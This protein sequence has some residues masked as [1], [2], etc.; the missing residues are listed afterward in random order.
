MKI[1]DVCGFYSDRGGGV[2]TYVRQK[3]LRAAAAGHEAAVI[4]PGE[5]DWVEQVEGGVVHWVTSPRMPFDANYRLLIS[6]EPVWSI[7]DREKPDI[8]E[9]SS[10]WRG[11]W[12]AGTWPGDAVKSLVFHQD[13][14]AG[15][16]Y[17]LLGGVMDRET[18]DSLFT[19]YW[20]WLRRLSS[21]F[22]VTLTGADW[23]ADRVRSFGLNNPISIP[24]GVDAGRF[25]AHLRDEGLRA[26]LLAECGLPPEAKLLLTVGRLHPEKRH[27]TMLSGFAMARSQ[28]QDLGL[29]I[30]GEGMLRESVARRA[31]MIGGVRLL[32]AVQD[33]DHLARLYASADLLVHG[34]GAETFGLVVAEALASGL[35][36][37]APNWGGAADLARRGAAVTY[38]TGDA[39]DCTRAI[40][41]AVE[42]LQPAAMVSPNAVSTGE[43]HFAALFKLYEE[44]LSARSAGRVRKD[45]DQLAA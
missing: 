9:G 13:F 29:V 2:K 31:Q 17:T 23:L 34:S 38:Q 16:P 21:R 44:L 6:A 18:I 3:L 41:Q 33:R 10:P 1:I 30:I 22:D 19:P 32:G 11:G 4:A 45:A 42:S 20:A 25:G 14:V 37:V 15:Y 27:R 26:R 24:F 12:I 28:R 7:L 40:L 39:R 8:V 5:R 35:P 43:E 36:V